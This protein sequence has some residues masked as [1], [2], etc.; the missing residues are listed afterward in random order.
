MVSVAIEDTLHNGTKK[1][2]FAPPPILGIETFS[3]TV[4][5]P[6]SILKKEFKGVIESKCTK[7]ERLNR[8]EKNN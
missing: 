7:M 5:N 2:Q 6:I 3:R 8:E 1:H 4:K